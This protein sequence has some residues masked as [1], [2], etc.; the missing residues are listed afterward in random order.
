VTPK[1]RQDHENTSHSNSLCYSGDSD[2]HLNFYPP[3]RVCLTEA[4][5]GIQRFEGVY[6]TSETGVISCE[7]ARYNSTWPRM[8]LRR[9]GNELFLHREDGISTFQ[10]QRTKR[11]MIQQRETMA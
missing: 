3:N 5:Y 1:N 7:F 6:Q 8:I 9:V 11:R 2:S 4:G 10:A